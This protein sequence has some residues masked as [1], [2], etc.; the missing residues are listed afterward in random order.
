MKLKINTMKKLTLIIGLLI[1]TSCTKTKEEKMQ[2]SISTEFKKDMNDPSTFEFVSMNIAKTFT[3]GERKKVMN[4]ASIKEMEKSLKEREA[5]GMDN[6]SYKLLLEQTKK[7]T[8]FLKSKDDNFEAVYYIDFVARGS[9][10]FGAII[11]KD[12]SATVLNDG[13]FTVVHL[14]SMN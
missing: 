8:E 9:N 7:E 14:K 1:F 5:Y 11:K 12:Y 4:E 2:E 6:T 10:S 3:A 13:S